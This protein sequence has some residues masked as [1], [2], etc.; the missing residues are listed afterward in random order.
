M[1]KISALI[2]KTKESIFSVYV[3]LVYLNIA[4]CS[5]TLRLAK[6]VSIPV[7]FTEHIVDLNL[8]VMKME[9]WH[10]GQKGFGM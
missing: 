2:C 4:S 6:S 3:H 8:V 9:I 7:W 10:Q 1:Q 5:N